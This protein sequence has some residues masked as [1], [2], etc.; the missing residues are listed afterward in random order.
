MWSRLKRLMENHILILKFTILSLLYYLHYILS[1]ARL[2]RYPNT[3]K[4]Y[5][6]QPS[7]NIVLIIVDQIFYGSIME[8]IIKLKYLSR[9]LRY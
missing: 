7:H 8:K 6:I 2:H 4:L 3:T 5:I 1:M 9:V